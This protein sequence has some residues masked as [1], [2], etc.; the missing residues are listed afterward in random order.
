MNIVIL[1]KWKAK[2]YIP[3]KENSAIIRIADS[4][5]E[6]SGVKGNFKY[7]KSFFFWDI[8]GTDYEATKEDI[9]EVV[10]FLLF[11]KEKGIEEL[12]VHCK[13]GQGRS[14][15]VGYLA[16]LIFNE[17]FDLEKYPNINKHVIK[18]GQ[19]ILKGK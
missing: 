10:D 18:L 14:P 15:A 17:S 1:D 9:E 16:S 7:N 3:E 5:T 11:L 13:Y 8:E 4:P 12:L 2:Q 6:L 19:E